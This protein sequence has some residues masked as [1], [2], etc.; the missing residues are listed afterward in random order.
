[1]PEQLLDWL[2][3]DISESPKKIFGYTSL[4]KNGGLLSY[5]TPC[6]TLILYRHSDRYYISLS[7]WKKENHQKNLFNS[8]KTFIKAKKHY[9]DIKINL[10]NGYELE[11]CLVQSEQYKPKFILID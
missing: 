10:A 7:H 5:H 11:C 4:L 9:D 8:F 1:M 2:N 3:D 6:H